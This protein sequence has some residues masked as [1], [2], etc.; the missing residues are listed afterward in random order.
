MYN[1]T[2][3]LL[4]SG[5]SDSEFSGQYTYTFYNAYNGTFT[6]YMNHYNVKFLALSLNIK[7]GQYVFISYDGSY[8]TGT[9]LIIYPDSSKSDDSTPKY[10]PYPTPAPTEVVPKSNFF[11]DHPI[12][13]VFLIYFI[14]VIVFG[15]LDS[16]VGCIYPNRAYRAGCKMECCY[17]CCTNVTYH[18]IAKFYSKH[19]YGKCCHCH[20]CDGCCKCCKCECGDNCNCNGECDPLGICY[21]ILVM[22]LFGLALSIIFLPFILMYLFIHLLTPCGGEEREFE[23]SGFQIESSSSSDKAKDANNQEM[24]PPQYNQNPPPGY[25]PYYSNQPPQ[26]PPQNQQ[27]PYYP[28]QPQQPYPQQN[29]NYQQPPP[30][31]GAPPPPQMQGQQPYPYQYAPQQQ[32]QSPYQQPSPYG[33][34][35]PMNNHPPNQPPMNGYPQQPPPMNNYPPS[36]QPMNNSA[37]LTQPQMPPSHNNLPPPP[38]PSQNH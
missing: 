2:G 13:A 37:P 17:N 29:Y 21:L 36:Q 38:P 23:K 14:S 31:G 6:S 32:P 7:K 15:I 33:A 9:R 1:T 22:F 12:G 20:C 3:S 11:K 25:P 24:V 35:P 30:Y 5:S 19:H 27:Q 18:K 10:T 28:N 4:I 8:N 26:Q 34:P 16:I